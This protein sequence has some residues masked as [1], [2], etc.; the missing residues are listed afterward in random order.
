[1]FAGAIR[2]NAFLPSVFRSFN[3]L[4]LPSAMGIS[5]L[6][7]L[8]TPFDG[9]THAILVGQLWAA[10]W[11]AVSA[12][13]FFLLTRRLLRDWQSFLITLFFVSSY[14]V[15]FVSTEVEVY[16]ISLAATVGLYLSLFRRSPSLW[17]AGLLWGMAILGHITNILLVVPLF[18]YCV[19]IRRRSWWIDFAVLLA[20]GYGL[21]FLV[22]AIVGLFIVRIASVSEFI[23]WVISYAGSQQAYGLF[24]IKQLG[25]GLLGLKRAFVAGPAKALMFGHAAVLLFSAL[26]VLLRRGFMRRLGIVLFF[27]IITYSLFFSWW[28]PLNIE[29]WVVTL[30]PICLLVGAGWREAIR[31][32]KQPLF[33]ALIVVVLLIQGIFNVREV[34]LRMDS[35]QDV[36]MERGRRI[37]Q[38]IRSQDLVITFNDP[39]VFTL[40]LAAGHLGA[41]SVDMLAGA[42]E[43]D[44]DLAMDRLSALIESA[45]HRGG[46]IYVTR[47][48]LAPDP[49]QLQRLS[50]TLDE[51]IQQLRSV[52][53]SE[54]T[55][56]V[57][58]GLIFQ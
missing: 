24:T 43:A 27:H 2:L 56:P 15:W 34:H 26:L 5:R 4:Y 45:R 55:R 31:R 52:T 13:L 51:Y 57:A 48:G 6:I 10:L 3:M 54:L 47:E 1:M 42:A 19:L 12:M 20:V 37:V 25:L 7:S 35:S 33:A 50:I 14:S 36:W 17:I 58:D 16:T 8:L 40:P 18:C 21:A 44:F 23:N 38:A 11:G 39:I 30:L 29:F 28:E 46:Y 9:P 32:G 49:L 53:Q 22:Y 41:V